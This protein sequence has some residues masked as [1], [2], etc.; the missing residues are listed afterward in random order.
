MMVSEFQAID[1]DSFDESELLLEPQSPKTLGE[2]R[3]FCGRMVQYFGVIIAVVVTITICDIIKDASM[4]QRIQFNGSNKSFRFPKSW[5]TDSSVND[6]SLNALLR[7]A[8][9]DYGRKIPV[10]SGKEDG[11][12]KYSSTVQIG[13]EDDALSIREYAMQKMSNGKTEKQ[14]RALVRDLEFAYTDVREMLRR[15]LRFPSVEQRVNIPPC[16]NDGRVTYSYTKYSKNYLLTLVEL[17]LQQHLSALQEPRMFLVNSNFNSSDR[18]D[19]TFDLVHFL[20]RDFF[21]D[22]RHRYCRDMVENLLPSFDRVLNNESGLFS[23]DIE[24]SNIPILYQFGDL[25]KTI[26]SEVL[27][28][29]TVIQ[30][31]RYPRMPV[32]QKARRRIFSSLLKS[33]TDDLKYQCY[34]KNERRAPV[35]TEG[36]N[37]SFGIGDYQS[38]H[39]EPIIFKLKTQR[40]YGK[41]YN[42][43]EA[44]LIPWEE[45][46]NQAVFRGALTGLYPNDLKGADIAK[47]S[48]VERC[49]LLER[50]WLTYSHASSK[51]V[52]VRLTEPYG[53]S[54]MI[55][56][57]ITPEPDDVKFI[58]NEP[59]VALNGDSLTMKD[60]LEYKALIMLEGNDIS[61]GLKWALFSNSIV[62]MPEP[63]LTSWSMEE[64]L[65]PW[66]HYV[67]INVLKDG[68]GYT[69]TDTEEK[70]QWIIDND[71]KAKE[72]VKAGKL[73]IADLV[74][75]PDVYFDEMKIIDDIAQRYVTHFARRPGIV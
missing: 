59:T 6:N 1:N 9:S 14:L 58:A 29:G 47:L 3:A 70:M 63:S 7:N 26:A 75:H 27:S 28:N 72:I 32:I 23:D 20:D 16:D 65:I 21:L 53:K 42:V 36:D 33:V 38:I 39:L 66:V 24:F 57:T 2:R 60:L 46:K 52:D 19:D 15:P 73:W 55:P 4:M 11:T 44:D 10:K 35:D 34:Q 25:P 74:L 50:C 8:N 5:P 13:D 40:H 22:C 31:R 71:E 67:P 30:L 45:K 37:L 17:S 68:N 51:L 61:S 62:L 18:E 49:R 64:M 48:I 12:W 43:A 56:S 54:R 41:I 69:A